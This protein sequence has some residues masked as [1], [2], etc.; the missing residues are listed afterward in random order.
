[1]P[2][3]NIDDIK[4]MLVPIPPISE[5]K[6]IIEYLDIKCSKIDKLTDTKKV[7][8]KELENLKKA[9]IYEYVTGKKE[10]K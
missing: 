5:Q 4:N 6:E 10:V 1:M 8:V 3:A 9:I 7:I 2:R